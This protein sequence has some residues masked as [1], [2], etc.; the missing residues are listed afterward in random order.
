MSS[1]QKAQIIAIVIILT[2]F[3]AVAWLAPAGRAQLPDKTVTPNAAGA[4]INKSF[5]QQAGAGRGDLMTPDSS[6]FIINR[7]PF[8]AIRRGR[9]LFQRKYTRAQGIGPLS[10]DGTGNIETTLAIG[11]GLVDSCAGCHG[12]PRGAAGS[13]GDVVTRPDSRDAPHLF[14]LGLKEML[15]DEITSD[16]RALRQQAIDEARRAPSDQPVIKNLISK[17]INYGAISATRHGNQVD[18]DTSAVAG[19]DADLRVRPFFAHGGTISIREF[20]VGAWHAEMGLQSVDPDLAAAHGGSRITTPAGMVLD[21]AQ[22]QIEAPPTSAPTEDPDGDGVSNEIPTSIVDFMEFY[23]LNYFKPATYEQTSGVRAGRQKFQEVGCT[24]CHIPDLQ[25]NRDR[26]VADLET[27]YDPA[28]GIFNNLFG[29]ASALFTQR[30]DGSGFPLL[31][32]SA[33]Q[34]FLVRDIFTDFKRHDLGPNFYE[35]NYDGTMRKQFLTTPLWGVGTTA[36]YG[37]DGRSI[38]LME[39]ILRHGGEARAARDAF[40]ALAP[41]DRLKLLEFLNSLVLFPPDDTASNLDPGNRGAAGFPQFGHGS[42][43]LT[44]LFNDPFDIE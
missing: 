37:H 1:K 13:G 11:A 16:L 25:L 38:N 23:L 15:A 18:L 41:G 30:D 5:I 29:T 8:R 14:G 12:R 39:V 28:S 22:D 42:V 20:A 19:V 21:G 27:V 34:P 4:G 6:L 44:V 33:N 7:D 17:G 10:G 3:A 26:R 32:R 35:R 36:P 24:Q 31:K 43:K 2:C 40:A 9:Q